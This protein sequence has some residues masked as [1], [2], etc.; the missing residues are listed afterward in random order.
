MALAFAVFWLTKAVFGTEGPP[1]GSGSFFLFVAFGLGVFAVGAYLALSPV[2]EYRKWLHRV[3]IVTDRRMITFDRRRRATLRRFDV[4]PVG[5]LMC[6][7]HRDGTSDVLV[8]PGV[9]SEYD[10]WSQHGP[11]GFLRIRDADVVAAWL[12]Q[13]STHYSPI[14]TI[15]HPTH[16]RPHVLAQR[17][18]TALVFL[19]VL[20]LV[21]CGRPALGGVLFFAI[22]IAII[23]CAFVLNRSSTCPRCGAR[24]SR[25]AQTPR[26]TYYFTCAKCRVRWASRIITS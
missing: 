20:P 26:G 13:L 18:G 8:A 2:R 5:E 19:G 6:V 21:F 11:L 4:E 1:A 25:D 12:A 14:P 22:V 9:S 17:V 24:L 16:D 15:D 7:E 23:A 10:A 3:Y